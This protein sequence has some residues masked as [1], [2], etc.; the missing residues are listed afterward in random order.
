MFFFSYVPNI[1]KLN[2]KKR[3][4]ETV[5]EELL[6]SILRKGGPKSGR[7]GYK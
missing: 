2:I 4:I 5:K 1:P 3:T 6:G 7:G